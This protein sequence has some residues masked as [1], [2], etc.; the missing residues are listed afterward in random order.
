MQADVD[1]GVEL[2]L[3]LAAI[4]WVATGK[5][6]AAGAGKAALRL[7]EAAGAGGTRGRASEPQAIVA[8]VSRGAAVPEAEEARYCVRVASPGL[9]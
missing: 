9:R 7:Q 1:C 8:G 3:Q 2:L 4:G 6:G 5:A